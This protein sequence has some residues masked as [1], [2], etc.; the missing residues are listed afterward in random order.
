M[1]LPAENSTRLFVSHI[2]EEAEIAALLKQTI[3][4]DFLDLVKLFQSSDIGSIAAGDDWLA[5]VQQAL[6]RQGDAHQQT[7]VPGLF[8]AGDVS[9]GLNQ[10]SV[11]IGEAAVA[12]AAAHRLLLAPR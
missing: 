9:R 3:E 4:E 12:A 5:A 10:I 7:A 2:S 1:P 6:K 8:V 11:A